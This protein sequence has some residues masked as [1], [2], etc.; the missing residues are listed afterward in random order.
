[1]LLP[2]GP[3]FAEPWSHGCPSGEASPSSGVR[4]RRC[5]DQAGGPPRPPC[6]FAALFWPRSPEPGGSTFGI[7][8]RSCSTAS[9]SV[10]VSGST[11][12]FRRNCAWFSCRARSY[13]DDVIDFTLPPDFRRRSCVYFRVGRQHASSVRTKKRGTSTCVSD[14]LSLTGFDTLLLHS[15]QHVAPARDGIHALL[16][17]HCPP[18]IPSDTARVPDVASPGISAQPAL[19]YPRATPFRHRLE[20]VLCRGQRRLPRTLSNAV[21]TEG[22]E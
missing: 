17:G 20:R 2:P 13:F 12:V 6:T 5:I 11:P 1:M 18:D 15:C 21:A 4:T 22:N 8:T 16:V 3:Q 7:P 19:R 14:A 9:I 10:K